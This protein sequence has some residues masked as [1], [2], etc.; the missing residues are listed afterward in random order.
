PS[1]PCPSRST[2]RQRGPHD[3]PPRGRPDSPPAIL[4]EVPLRLMGFAL[5][6]MV[7]LILAPLAAE[8]QQTTKLHRIGILFPYVAADPLNEKM[9]QAFRDLGYIEGHTIAFEWRYVGGDT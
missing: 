8:A 5:V 9:R 3:A 1:G 2:T 4:T 7:G 6:L